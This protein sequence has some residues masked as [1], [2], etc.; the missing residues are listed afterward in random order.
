MKKRQMLMS[1]ILLLCFSLVAPSLNAGDAP[2]ETGRYVK[3]YYPSK[4]IARMIIK[5]FEPAPPEVNYQDGYLVVYVTAES[6]KY[7]ES[8]GFNLADYPDY[9]IFNQRSPQSAVM[10]STGGIPGYTCYQTVEETFQQAQDIV[11]AHP[12]LAQWSDVGNSWQKE[13]SGI[14]YDMWVLKLTNNQ[15]GYGDKPRLFITSAIHARE[16]TTAPLA[17]AFARHLVDNYATDA[18]ARWILDHNE[19]HLMLHANPDGRKKAEAGSSWRKNNN[20]TYCPTS[21]P[22]ADLNRNFAYLWGGAGSS[23]SQC[24]E[25]YRG[26]SAASE[27]ETRAIQ[28]YMS[29]IFDDHNGS[30]PEQPVADDAS[31]LY[32]DIHSYSELVLW[33]WG[34]TTVAAPNGTQLQTLGRKFAYFNGYTPQQSVGLYPTTGTTDD[35][36]YGELGIASYCFEL[37]TAFFQSCADYQG[38]ILPGNLPALIYAAKVA[39]APYKIPAGPDVYGLSFGSGASLAATVSDTRY[40]NSN[41][42]EPV[43][44]IAAAEYYIDVPPWGPGASSLPLSATDGSF[45]GNVEQVSAIVNTSGLVPGEHIVYVRGQ[46][47]AGNWGPVSAIFL[48]VSAPGEPTASFLH[49]HALNDRTVSFQDTSSDANGAIV[50]WAWDFGDGATATDRNPVHTYAANGTYTVLLTV[51]DNDG[52]TASASS[53]VQVYWDGAVLLSNNQTLTGLSGSQGEWS[54]YKIAMPSPPGSASNL[55]I[56]ISG[57]TGDADLYTRHDSLPTLSAYGCRPYDYGNDETC[58]VA[59]PQPGIYGIGI[60]GYNDYSGVSLSVS[61]DE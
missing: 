42:A 32:I 19:I 46:D 24:S 13:N 6:A 28:N 61:Y 34:H 26:A 33:P 14:G 54:Y 43:Q 12:A 11:T 4:Q 1:F 21:K 40:N 30:A 47:T 25:T 3:A 29:S 31:G 20:T 45:S 51:T 15:A 7:L 37:G 17:L 16:Y 59:S 39:R 22:G 2:A 23:S 35:Y 57:G 52:N 48:N 41:G 27:P 10:S 36:G 53:R 5:S 50:S 58:T 49:N 9:T 8:L 38:D 55:V 60:R 18:D 56:S 44:N